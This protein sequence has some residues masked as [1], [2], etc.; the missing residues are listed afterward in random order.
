MNRWSNP[1]SD[2]LKN[3]IKTEADDCYWHCQ[4]RFLADIM[5]KYV[6]NFEMF[7]FVALCTDGYTCEGYTRIRKTQK[8]CICC[9]LD[10]FL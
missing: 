5:F 8:Y 7:C 3:G 4:F 6:S 9:A 1:I 2:S 10:M